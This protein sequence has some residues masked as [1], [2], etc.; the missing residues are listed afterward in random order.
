VLIA[1]DS[2]CEQHILQVF[3][4]TA[5]VRTRTAANASEVLQALQ[6][7]RF[8]V[9]LLDT[10]MPGMQG[11]EL[12]RRLRS[13][14]QHA[15]L[16]IIA[17]SASSC[18]RQRQAYVAL[19]VAEVLTKPADPLALVRALARCRRA[20]KPQQEDPAGVLDLTDLRFKLGQQEDVV[21]AVLQ[22]FRRQ[23]LQ[24]W[25]SLKR[26]LQRGRLQ[27]AC[28]LAH[29]LQGAA[30]NVGAFALHGAA[31]ALLASLQCG[32]PDRA[33]QA[34]FQQTLRQTLA[35]LAH[36]APTVPALASP[37]VGQDAVQQDLQRLEQALSAHDFVSAQRFGQLRRKLSP[38]QL[39][40]FDLLC[41]HTRELQY[42]QAQALMQQLRA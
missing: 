36:S 34:R 15:A 25:R 22:V 1:E 8:D 20:P 10:H 40:L 33:R 26:Q 29:T 24:H 14:A 21:Q 6:T 42:P 18:A 11:L 41:Q 13:E 3:L 32:N 37:R 7:A 23:S 2:P 17:L 27:D 28:L 35:A 4:H 16:A 39:A 5:G 12:A 9:L 31:T 38:R 30:A 19:G